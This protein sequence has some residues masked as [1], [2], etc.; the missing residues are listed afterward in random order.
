[1]LQIQ[2]KLSMTEKCLCVFALRILDF[3][4]EENRNIWELLVI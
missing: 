3:H 2:G 4:K 1:M